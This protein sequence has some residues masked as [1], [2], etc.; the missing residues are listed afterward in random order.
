LNKGDEAA[1][2]KLYHLIGNREQPWRPNALALL[3]LITNSNLVDCMTGRS[4]GF[5]PLPTR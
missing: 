5:S 2:V 3:R 4:A 1:G